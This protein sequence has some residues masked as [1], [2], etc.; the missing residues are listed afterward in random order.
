MGM[1][2]QPSENYVTRRNEAATVHAGRATP[3][4]GA[5]A[6]EEMAPGEAAAAVATNGTRR[7]R[8]KRKGGK[9]SRLSHD[10]QKRYR[11]SLDKT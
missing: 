6:K 4:V 8:G 10:A 3:E 1:M 7:A 2:G 9:Q 5:E 11:K